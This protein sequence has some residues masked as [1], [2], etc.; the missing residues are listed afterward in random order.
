VTKALVKL[1]L[2][3]IKW[4]KDHRVEEI[5]RGFAATSGFPRVIGEIDGTHI[6][7]RAPHVNPECYVNRKNHHSIHLQVIF[8]IIMNFYIVLLF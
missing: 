5:M 8:V 7:I 3:F 1:A 4:P 2:F 6:N